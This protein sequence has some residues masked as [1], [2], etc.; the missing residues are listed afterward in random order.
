[1]LSISLFFAIVYQVA[2][3]QMV[4]EA[5]HLE[6]LA[7]VL[8]ILREGENQIEISTPHLL[9]LKV[10]HNLHIFLVE[11]LLECSHAL[12]EHT[13]RETLVQCTYDFTELRVCYW[14]LLALCNFVAVCIEHGWFVSDTQQSV[15]YRNVLILG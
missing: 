7:V 1:M 4:S 11:T 14:L 10:Q 8:H 2:P 9:L 15:P 5:L 13:H 12:C 6:E 3:Q